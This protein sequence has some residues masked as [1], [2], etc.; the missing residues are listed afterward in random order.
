MHLP[1]HD[2]ALPNLPVLLDGA[3]TAALLVT[4]LADF[5][6]GRLDLVDCVPVYVRYKPGTS[7]LIQYRVQLR[8]VSSGD[9][10]STT[11]F[12]RMFSD[13]HG[14]QQWGRRSFGRLLAQADELHPEL[15][16]ARA[17]YLP[18]MRALLQVYPVDRDLKPLVRVAAPAQLRAAVQDVLAA[19]LGAP[20]AQQGDLIR[21]KPA[22][23][24]LLRVPWEGGPVDAA[25]VKVLS[26]DRGATL[27][28]AAESLASYGLR[29]PQVLAHLVEDRV[30]VHEA[31]AGVPLSA[32]RG[33]QE[34]CDAMAPT[35]EV[36]A[37]LHAS[38]VQGLFP[39]TLAVE[40][41]VVRIACETVRTLCPALAAR[42]DTLAMEVTDTLLVQS[43]REATLHGDFY[44]DQIL[45][46]DGEVAVIDLDE[47]RRGH[48][49]I[50]VG[51]MLAHLTVADARGVPMVDARQAFIAASPY[52]GEVALPV[53]ET[54]ALLK[55]AVGPFRRLEADWPEAMERIVACAER[56]FRERA[57]R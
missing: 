28:R 47:I 56:C 1:P 10:H 40:T 46:D 15:P 16:R 29:T 8:D 25:Y 53:F 17:A 20:A 44:D 13:E 26:D 37:R 32:L 48:P 21:Y 45:V 24:A 39:H 7:A 38:S 30:I 12:F 43:D 19:S 3:A 41:A 57:R 22:R 6:A 18:D 2:P 49:L 36:L 34:Y 5:N 55:L 50:D 4:S 23:K 9:L 51:N 54:A 14:A 52:G 27:T 11:A 42:M 31:I 35:V 33:T